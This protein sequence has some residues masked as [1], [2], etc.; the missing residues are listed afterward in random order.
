MVMTH[1]QGM[2]H[3]KEEV[4]V[5]SA[6]VATCTRKNCVFFSP[7]STC[8]HLTEPLYVVQVRVRAE[9]V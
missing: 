7:S 3:L 2:A 9:E 1:E 5:S 6:T 8:V 4:R